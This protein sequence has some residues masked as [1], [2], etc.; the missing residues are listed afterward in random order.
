MTEEIHLKFLEFLDNTV[1]I[2]TLAEQAIHRKE[3]VLKINLQDVNVHST[4]LH[5]DMVWNFSKIIHRIDRSTI[6]FTTREFGKSLENTSFFNS[7]LV[8]RIRELKTEL[9]G[10]LVSFC[11]T[12][13]RTTQVRPELING[14][15]L[16]KVCNSVVP[17]LMQK[18]KYT[19]PLVCPNHRCTN[20][21]SWKLEIDKSKFSEKIQMRYHLELF[22]GI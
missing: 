3:S 20:R 18:I 5:D 14:T 13:R 6:L 21:K 1:E 17:E 22:Q 12:I 11:G 8:Y 9:L 10:Q 2:K 19:E 16:C 15:F 4:D 7:H